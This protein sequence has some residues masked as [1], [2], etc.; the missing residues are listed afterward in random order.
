MLVIDRKVQMEQLEM[1]RLQ[2][3][4]TGLDSIYEFGAF[5]MYE[6]NFSVRRSLIQNLSLTV[7]HLYYLFFVSQILRFDIFLGS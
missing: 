4:W 2:V 6:N 3:F 1:I 7:T 5:L